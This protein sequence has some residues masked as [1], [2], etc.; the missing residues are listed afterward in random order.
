MGKQIF[1]LLIGLLGCSCSTGDGFFAVPVKTFDSFRVDGILTAK[2]T[3]S[4]S[5]LGGIGLAVSDSLLIVG[6]SGTDSFLSV[7]NLNENTVC[8]NLCLHGRGPGEY[9]VFFTCYKQFS[10]CGND[11]MLYT[12]DVNRSMLL[13]NLSSS[14]CQQ[15][16]VVSAEES[17]QNF[18]PFAHGIFYLEGGGL[19]VKYNTSYRDARDNRYFPARYVIYD[20]QR[21]KET[22]I[23][24]F[25]PEMVSDKMG[26]LVRTATDGSVLLKPDGTKI[27]DAM[28]NFGYIN[29]IDLEKQTGFAL[30]KENALTYEAACGL[31]D[32]ERMRRM[33]FSYFDLAVTDKY[34]FA[35]YSG[36]TYEAGFDSPDNVTTLRVFDWDGNPLASMQFDRKIKGIAFRERTGILYGLDANENIVTYDLDDLLKKFGD[37]I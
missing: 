10:R 32:E 4:V 21:K 20:K 14:L 25:G 7:V 26:F 29:F 35:A 11:N 34:V 28:F 33:R 31:S 36:N 30:R 1:I 13:V 18:A 12:F 27:V 5:G 2:D 19:F 15:K 37:E 8:D 24:F 9:S 17:I 22:E 16:T 23:P 3:L 6:K